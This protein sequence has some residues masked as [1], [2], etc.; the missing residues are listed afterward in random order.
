MKARRAIG[1][2][3]KVYVPMTECVFLLLSAGMASG[4]VTNVHTTFADDPKTEIWASWRGESSSVQYGTTTSYGQSAVGASK[5]SGGGT[6]HNAK[7]TGLMPGTT[8]YYRC[9][10]DTT[11]NGSFRTAPSGN[12][13][14]S[15]YVPGDIQ[16]DYNVESSWISATRFIEGKNVS[17]WLPVGDI[18]SYGRDP[19]CWDNFYLGG[20]ALIPKSVMAPMIGNHELYCG[21]PCDPTSSGFTDKWIATAWPTIYFDQFPLPDNGIDSYKG[22]W[23]SFEYGDA[24]FVVMCWSSITADA[25]NLQTAWLQQV[26]STTGKKWKFAFLHQ[27]IYSAARS[28]ATVDDLPEWN[29]L[30]EQYH[31]NAVFS[32]HVHFFETTV[33]IKDGQMAGSYADG[34]LY[35]NTALLGASLEA[36]GNQ[37]TASK[38]TE[39]GQMSCVVEVEQDSVEVI[40]YHGTGGS[41]WD[42][43]TLTNPA[44]TA[45]NNLPVKEPWADARDTRTVFRVAGSQCA[46]SSALTGMTKDLR[47]YDL[48][49]KEVRAGIFGKASAKGVFIAGRQTNPK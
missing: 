39:D 35:Y 26:L 33:P 2:L 17:F 21:H 6:Q 43:I 25:Y 28:A 48:L 29:A 23:Y 44:S 37:F 16:G 34:T 31:V 4:A 10:D 14:F 32:G 11:G 15:F 18:T 47:V 36:V 9:G 3:A 45:V 1:L 24:L 38:Q 12:A 7:L 40:T 30:W 22:A 20:K 27:Q 5:A 46:V 42:R 19:V 49:G 41:I 8:Y 13:P